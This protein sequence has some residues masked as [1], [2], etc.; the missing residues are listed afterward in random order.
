MFSPCHNKKKNKKNKKNPHQNLPEG[1]E[2]QTGNLEQRLT[3]QN[4][5]L[6]HHLW[7]SHPPSQGWSPTISRMVNHNFKD[8]HHPSQGWEPIMSR[9]V[10]HLPQ[11]GNSPTQDGHQRFKGWSRSPTI[12]MMD[13][14]HPKDGLRHEEGSVP[15]T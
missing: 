14:F 8:S 1:S 7:Y 3:S 4:Y 5:D 15:K 13:N 2:L 9:M 11:D 10:I 12:L 6:T